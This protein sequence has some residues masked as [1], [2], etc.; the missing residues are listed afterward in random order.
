LSV[1]RKQPIRY[2]HQYRVWS[3]ALSMETRVTLQKGGRRGFTERS[4]LTSEK[5]SFPNC[6]WC[7]DS[8]SH[9]LQSAGVVTG[10]KKALSAL[11]LGIISWS[12]VTIPYIQGVISRWP[13]IR[14][15]VWTQLVHKGVVKW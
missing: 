4:D 3:R 9:C 6:K 15:Q 2:H 12:G 13:F 14:T 10:V 1:A 11:I 8:W 7:K 5:E